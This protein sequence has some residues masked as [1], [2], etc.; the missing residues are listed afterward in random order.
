MHVRLGFLVFVFDITSKKSFDELPE[1]IDNE[2]EILRRN[3]GP[4]SVLVG[5]VVGNKCDLGDLRQVSS[6][7]G[8]NLAA[9]YNL[10]YYETSAKADISIPSVFLDI[11]KCVLPFA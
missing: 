1:R 5:A 7:K 6:K 2:I 3:P 4:D 10:R 11:A 9:K 8:T